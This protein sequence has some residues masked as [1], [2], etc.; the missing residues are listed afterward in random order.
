MPGE[1]GADE[2]GSGC[3]GLVLR[4]FDLRQPQSSAGVAS[5]PKTGTLGWVGKDRAGEGEN[6]SLAPPGRKGTRQP[7]SSKLYPSKAP[8]N[9]PPMA[10]NK[11]NKRNSPLRKTRKPMY[12]PMIT[13]ANAKRIAK[14]I[15][16]PGWPFNQVPSLVS[17][18]RTPTRIKSKNTQVAPPPLAWSERETRPTK[19]R[20]IP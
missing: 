17:P 7:Y 5:K 20:P 6:R 15:I 9:V 16:G 4:I 11:P 19:S 3:G 8:S 2:W 14:R 12:G 13:P 1:V 18:H 10:P